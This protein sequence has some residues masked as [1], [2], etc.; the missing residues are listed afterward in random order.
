MPS[1]RCPETATRSRLTIESGVAGN[2]RFFSGHYFHLR[3]ISGRI[4]AS[5]SKETRF[6]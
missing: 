5:G 3:F 4:A 2:L 6:R 1:P